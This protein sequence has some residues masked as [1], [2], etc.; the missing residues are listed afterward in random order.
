V[1]A[2]IAAVVATLGF[3]VAALSAATGPASAAGVLRPASSP[4][5][6]AASSC[7]GNGSGGFSCSA[8]VE[9][10][11]PPYTGTWNGVPATFDQEES[12]YFNGTCVENSQVYVALVVKDSAS[13]QVIKDFS[14]KCV[15]GISPY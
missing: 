11:Q 7:S 6:E 2:R 1:R 8:F 10:G 12:T 4:T 13:E 5:I 3:T 15:A 14:F 9:G